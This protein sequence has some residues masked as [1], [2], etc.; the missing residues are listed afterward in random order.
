VP[1]PLTAREHQ[2]LALIAQG[3]PSSA[4]ATRLGASVHT[5]R[6][7]RSNMLRKL[8]LKGTTALAAYAVRHDHPGPHA[9]RGMPGEPG[10]GQGYRRASIR[11]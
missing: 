5:V 9:G 3:L 8:G 11:S 4:I 10:N 2:V 7:H 1:P 6:K